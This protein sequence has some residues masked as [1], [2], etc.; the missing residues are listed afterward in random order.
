MAKEA[1]VAPKERVNIVYKAATGD[2]QEEKEL[3]LK[4]LM[5]GDYTQRQDGTPVEDRAAIPVNKD[6]FSDVM[7]G[8]KLG[9]TLDVENRLADTPEGSEAGRMAVNLQFRS[10]NDFRPEA[11]AEQVPEL[12]QLLQ[13]RSALQAL[14]G[15][16]GNV[17]A[18]RQK[19]ESIIGDAALRQKILDELE[20][21]KD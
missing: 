20:T 4:L 9:L 8:M 2:A 15:P 10:M 17:P 7:Q 5:L 18:F 3:P 1:S 21:K 14:K 16:L 6:N 19:I 11:V 12:N 13:L